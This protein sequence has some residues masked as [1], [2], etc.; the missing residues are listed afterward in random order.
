MNKTMDLMAESRM[1]SQMCPKRNNSHHHPRTKR[2]SIHSR[3]KKP[4]RNSKGFASNA[5]DP[6]A[7]SS[8]KESAAEH[9]TRS[10]WKCT[11][12]DKNRRPKA[13]TSTST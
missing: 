6:N 8:A 12:K 4:L 2:T 11:T 13:Q 3:K 7:L 1:K 5:K 10:V 9:S